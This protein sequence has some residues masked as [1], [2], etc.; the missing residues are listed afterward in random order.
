MR[1]GENKYFSIIEGLEKP[2]KEHTTINKDKI[3]VI[4]NNFATNVHKIKG[5]KDSYRIFS[6]I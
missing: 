1:Y 2:I 5:K 4:I 6:K 3:F